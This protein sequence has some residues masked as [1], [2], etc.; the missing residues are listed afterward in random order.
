MTQIRVLEALSTPGSKDRVNEDALGSNEHCAFVL[1]GATGLGD[2]QLVDPSGSDAAWLARS[3]AEWFS[4][5]MTERCDAKQIV[6]DFITASRREFQDASQGQTVPRYAW[7]SAS[8][9]MLC[10]RE[11][12]VTFLGLGDCTLYVARDDAVE[13]HCAL[14]S[15][16]TTETKAAA[17][18]IGR[19]GGLNDDGNLLD[20]RETLDGLR[21]AR[22]LQ[23]TV[24]GG[25]WTLGLE[26][27]ATDH[28]VSEGI[29]IKPP[30]HALLCSDGFSALVETYSRYSPE[31]LFD[32]ALSGGLE[33]L[34]EELRHIENEIDPHATLYPRFKRSDDATAMLCSVTD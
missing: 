8:L 5:N 29:G 3:A 26:P 25:I 32:A 33:K 27:I 30:F 31:T 10:R 13:R 12:H 4:R 28:I 16:A 15:F 9:A 20:H 7:P 34:M 2:E 1:D 23:N 21:R 22:E 24:E 6:H 14:S 11:D 17:T 19:A 18:Q